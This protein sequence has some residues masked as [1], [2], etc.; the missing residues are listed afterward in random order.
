MRK[1][2]SFIKRHAVKTAMAFFFFMP[3]APVCSEPCFAAES[4]EELA[5]RGELSGDIEKL[6]L[7]LERLENAKIPINSAGAVELRQLPWLDASDIHDIIAS[8]KKLPFADLQHLG[9]IIGRNKAESV[10]PYIS[11]ETPERGR[12]KREEDG[13]NGG[14]TSRIYR[15]YPSRRG[16]LNGKYAGTSDKIYNRVLLA[17]SGCTFGYLQERDIGEPEFFDFSSI[18]FGFAGKGFVKTALLGNY[19]LSL[20]QG[21]MIGQGRYY[22]SGADLTGSVRLSSKRLSPYT[23]SSESGFFQGGALALE[24]RPFEVTVFYSAN[25]V[26]AVV[27]KTS[28][29]ITSFDDSGYHRTMTER[30]RKDNVTEKVCGANLLWHF[31]SGS[32]EGR[33]GGSWM[34]YDYGMP[35]KILGGESG[36]VLAGLEAEATLGRFG[37]FGEAAWAQLPGNCISWNAG[38]EWKVAKGVSSVL[39]VRDYSTGYFSPFASAF[40]ERGELGRNEQGIYAA[41]GMRLTD[42]LTVSGYYDRFRF[43]LLDDH[44]PFPSEGHDSRAYV[45]WKPSRKVSLE[46]Q[47]QHKYKEEERNQGTSKV[48]LWTALPK[49][50]E[51]CRLDC[52]IDIS[53]HLR[54]SALGE[55]KTARKKYLA[56]DETNR[57]WLAY[58][59]AGYTVSTFS[60]KG[61]YTVFNVEDYDAAIY[62][63]EYDL[64]Q[65]FNMG[66]YNGRG[67]SV[68]V[69]ASWQVARQLKLAGRFEKV[70]YADREVYGSGN[71]Q[72][73][74]SS[75][76]S[77]NIGVYLKF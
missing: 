64:P 41:L 67:R 74:T 53:D 68:A 1:H 72:R 48:P 21:L 69:L 71:D 24:L 34:R 45:S 61:R 22:A 47:L 31:T 30:F 23:S 58:G 40:A 50:S 9:A 3:A 15:E 49:I 46:L 26:D 12:K 11:F 10:S 17:F 27:N 29:M 36:S 75:P 37:L 43:P 52:D 38:A 77:F 51:R 28:G 70:W 7:D 13:F 14:I 39:A 55:F 35:M 66:M 6:M 18:T 73:A 65:T 16:V 33:I 2:L 42:R 76:S 25:K 19:E 32:A 56:G 54:L 63:Y 44:C 62:V 4:I 59:Q 60:L 20:G 57:G 8:R 5:G